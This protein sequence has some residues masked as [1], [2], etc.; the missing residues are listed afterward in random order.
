M[1]SESREANVDRR[2]FIKYG[3]GAA[4][5][6]AV[7]GA[8]AYLLTQP[9]TVSP[10]PTSATAASTSAAPTTVA[11]SSV[12]NPYQEFKLAALHADIVG[13]M[14]WQ[15]AGFEGYDTLRK[16][17]GIQ[18]THEEGVA[19]YKDI[20]TS[21]RSYA[22][23]GYDLI[24]G[25]GFEY[26]DPAIEVAPDFPNTCFAVAT[27]WKVAN[28]VSQYDA[29]Q[30]QASYLLGILAGSLTKT[31]KIGIVGAEKVPIVFRYHEGMK[32]GA[33]AVNSKVEFLEV[34]TGDWFDVVKARDAGTAQLDSGADIMVTSADGMS[35]GVMEA[36]KNH[37]N[38]PLFTNYHDQNAMAPEVIITS[39]ANEWGPIFKQM[40]DDVIAKKYGNNIYMGDLANGGLDIAPYHNWDSVLP[41]ELKDR[42]QQA[43]HDIIAGKIQITI[44]E[45]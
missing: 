26:Q 7:A 12:A 19:D 28:N 32:Q 33:Q 3:I 31:N 23:Q 6:V 25:H 35:I 27:G 15:Q 5:V 20:V 39:A 13:D 44:P 41:Q 2:R 17:L 45:E 18:V 22:E 24:L 16:E 29:K 9:T 38:A 8:G 14:S 1:T 30:E 36:C 42:V 21:L 11:T 37:N 34:Y 4:A 40:I 43:K 10:T